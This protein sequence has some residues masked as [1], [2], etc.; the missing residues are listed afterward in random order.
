MAPDTPKMAFN[1]RGP[2]NFAHWN[3]FPFMTTPKT[4]YILGQKQSP[5][6]RLPREI[7]NTI[8]DYYA[9]SR[10]RYVYDKDTAKL[11][12]SDTSAQTE[13][14]GLMMTCKI[15]A[16]EMQHIAFQN[17]EF[18][19]LCSADDG[20]EF[21]QLRSR[22][23]R[24]CQIFD[25]VQVQRQYMLI[26]VAELLEA[27]D[28]TE[29]RARY[30]VIEDCLEGPLKQA[31]TRN[32]NI[33]S[34]YMDMSLDNHECQEFVEAL[35]LAL[36]MAKSRDSTKFAR[37]TR[38]IFGNIICPVGNLRGMGQYNIFV[39]G[40]LHDV[41]Y[42]RPTPWSIPTDSELARMEG[43][44]CRPEEDK[45][46]I[47]NWCHVEDPRQLCNMYQFPPKRLRNLRKLV[48]HEDFKS[49]PRSVCH[50]RGLIPLCQANSKLRIERHI[51]L[52]ANLLPLGHPDSLYAGYD[53]IAGSDVLDATI[54]W[55][56]EVYLLHT[57]GMPAGSFRLVIDGHSRESLEAWNIL[58]YAAAMQ[59][60]MLEQCR[61]KNTDPTS[62][63]FDRRFLC[64]V[65][66]PWHLPDGFSD[67]IRAV[68]DGTI[69]ITFTGDV[70]EMWDQ[71]TFFFKRRD[72]TV[73]EWEEEWKDEVWIKEIST[74]YWKRINARYQIDPQG[75]GHIYRTVYKGEVIR[76]SDRPV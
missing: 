16:D 11:R 55:L 26:C 69:N 47:Y 63:L 76:S 6:F 62:R 75:F 13:G 70:G 38:G 35:V 74:D 49:M 20:A 9:R 23:A 54:P 64:R 48:L 32:I 65:G 52:L 22:A 15:A 37:L 51:D 46:L 31:V 24:F 25:M 8:Y 58:K 50:V 61:V 17:V 29:I 5:L 7:R 43:L 71:D 30:P 1:K 36:D 57:H 39:E 14:L 53:S 73:N 18:S 4:K 45:T 66:L 56:M 21:Q 42:W 40:A 60:A 59:E 2:N 27:S 33:L 34:Q 10:P 67:T 41:L 19:T 44:V 68:I 28:L 72:W 3:M 12:Y